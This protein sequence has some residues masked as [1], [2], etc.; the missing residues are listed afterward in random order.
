MFMCPRARFTVPSNIVLEYS[1]LARWIEL[2]ETNLL[3]YTFCVFG[4]VVMS[5]VHLQSTIKHNCV[6]I[7]YIQGTL[8]FFFFIGL[9]II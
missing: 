7:I 4:Q 2:D 1:N 9:H 6:I 3:P 8:F 5:N